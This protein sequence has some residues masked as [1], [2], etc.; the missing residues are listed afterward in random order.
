MKEASFLL[1]LPIRST[2]KT[3]KQSAAWHCH[4]LHNVDADWCSYAYCRCLFSNTPEHSTEGHTANL[5]LCLGTRLL[6]C[7]QR[8]PTCWSLSFTLFSIRAS[9]N[10]ATSSF[11]SSSCRSASFSLFVPP[12]LY[13]AWRNEA[14]LTQEMKASRISLVQRRCRQK[15][16]QIGIQLQHMHL[17]YGERVHTCYGVC[18]SS[19]LPNPHRDLAFC[20]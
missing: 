10:S 20:E 12:L 13:P 19:L 9:N 2:V 5:A 8:R 16:L 1:A 15:R 7:P 17:E 4:T 11:T 18:S 3:S 6:S 14:D